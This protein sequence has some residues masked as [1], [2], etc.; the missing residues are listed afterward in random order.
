MKFSVIE[1]ETKKGDKIKLSLEIESE[2][3]FSELTEIET[4]LKITKQAYDCAVKNMFI[5][6]T[7]T[8]VK[9]IIDEP[10]QN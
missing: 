10:H 6:D 2:R 9:H 1:K 3:D 4:I 7:E 8:F 5:K